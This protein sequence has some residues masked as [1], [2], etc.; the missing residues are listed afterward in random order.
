MNPLTC[1]RALLR[2][3]AETPFADRP[4]LAAFSGWSP[5]TVYDAVGRLEDSGLVEGL[6]HATE[7]IPPTRRFCLTAE[8]VLQLAREEGVATERMLRNRPLSAH[9]RRLLLGRLDGVA[10]IYRMAGAV[11][12]L[13]GPVGLRWYRASP[14]DVALLP[15][16]GRILGVVRQGPVAGRTAFSKRLRRLFERPLPAAL[17]LLIPDEVRLRHARRLLRGAP[18]PTFLA[19]ERRAVKAGPGERIWRLPSL[20]GVL[21]LEEALSV[22]RRSGL[23]PSE[24]LPR[25][26]LLPL[27]FRPGDPR[28]APSSLGRSEKRTL[29]ALY[30]WPWITVEALAGLLGVSPAHASRLALGLERHGLA[31]RITLA[32]RHRL[33]LSDRGLSLLARRDRSSVGK[34]LK[35]WSAAPVE[36][37]PFE[38]RNVSGSRSR[39]LLRNLEHTEAVHGFMAALAVQARG[40]GWEVIQLDPPH[41]ASRYF[42]YRERLHSVR[43]DGFGLLRREGRTWPFFLEW[44]RRAVR[45]ATMRRRLA[46]YLLYHATERP[47]E[48]H[49]ARPAV[50]IVFDGEIPQAHFLRVASEAME[51]AG[52]EVPLWVSHRDAVAELG[53]LDPA[54]WRRPGDSPG[55]PPVAR[56]GERHAALLRG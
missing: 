30:D 8:G 35:R 52:I 29:D 22:V 11:V 42:R 5:A 23:A 2:Q 4:E 17:L 50:L 18:L 27:R 3:L 54:A 28:L 40:L 21:T 24:P 31:L 36:P 34:A 51:R 12:D 6:P 26:V 19:Q 1:E 7:L 10:S 25:R 41:R 56:G 9:W 16:G 33:V 37:D 13:D 48:D 49:G 32:R 15:S 45:P 43:P 38:W 55:R 47:L 39:Q 46:P 20:S 53:P 44:E 14:L